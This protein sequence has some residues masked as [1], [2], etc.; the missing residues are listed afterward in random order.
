MPINDPKEV[1]VQILSSVRQG[2][3]QTTKIFQEI[4]QVTQHP[5]IKEAMEA[6]VFVSDTILAKLDQCFELIG[7]EPVKLSGRLHDVVAVNFRNEVA[8]IQNPMA[9]HLFVLATANQLIHLRT[10]EYVTLIAAADMTGHYGVGVL[11][12]SCLADNLAFVERTRRL[13]RKI[14]EVKATRNLVQDQLRSASRRL[15]SQTGGEQLR[16]RTLNG[17]QLLRTSIG[18]DYIEERCLK[19]IA[20]SCL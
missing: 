14:I 4:S 8:E 2:T 11:L 5:D 3:E 1:F 18:R 15:T 20:I 16:W 9:K 6:R 19:E 12:E 17:K 7:E 10:A 13:I